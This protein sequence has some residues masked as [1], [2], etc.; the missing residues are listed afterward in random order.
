MRQ[1]RRNSQKVHN[2]FIRPR[3]KPKRTEPRRTGDRVRLGREAYEAL[4]WDKAREAEN[5][6]QTC[7]IFAPINAIPFWSEIDKQLIYPGELSHK[8]HGANKSDTM[9]DTLWECRE[10]HQV[11]RHNPKSVPRKPGRRMNK[12]EA[13]SYWAGLKCFCEQP[14]PAKRSLC[15]TCMA[16]LPPQLQYDLENAVGGDW[17][18]AMALA[19]QALLKEK[20]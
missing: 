6:C 16:K 14:K 2:P 8:R 20:V 12:K 3:V 15:P 7:G 1:Q 5:H 17:L 13:P 19:E 10:C 9:E 11:E 18:T 4:R